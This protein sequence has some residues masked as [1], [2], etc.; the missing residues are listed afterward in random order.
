MNTNAGHS[1]LSSSHIEQFKKICG[2]KYVLT[3][4]EDLKNYA[5]DQTENLHFP[6]QV[7]L[8]VRA[9]EEISEV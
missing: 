6:P 4:E 5:H 7:V 3:N 8:K 2:E 9:A 1:N